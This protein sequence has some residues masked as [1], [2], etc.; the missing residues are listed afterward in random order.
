MNLRTTM[1]DIIE[2][3]VPAF[4]EQIAVAKPER[5]KALIKTVLDLAKDGIITPEMLAKFNI[6]YNIG[7]RHQH[8]GKIYIDDPV[9][10]GKK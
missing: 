7:R 8:T 4:N 5:K 2:A 6:E 3:M 9:K 10:E 1:K